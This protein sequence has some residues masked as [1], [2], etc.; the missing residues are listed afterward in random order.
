MASDPTS[1]DAPAA[2][3]GPGE[4]VGIIYTQLCVSEVVRKGVRL[5]REMFAREMG[6]M[7]N[8]EWIPEVAVDGDLE[9]RWV[10]PHPLPTRGSSTL[11]PPPRE[12]TQQADTRAQRHHAGSRTSRNISR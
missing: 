6:R 2:A 10:A 5:L 4:H 7:P 12:K 3:A 11:P 9:A 8:D 1:A